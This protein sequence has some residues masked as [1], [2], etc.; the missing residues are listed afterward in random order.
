MRSTI[1]SVYGISSGFGI[2][3]GQSIAGYMGENNWRISFLVVALPAIMLAILV[4]T[5]TE[6]IQRGRMEPELQRA[7]VHS[8][9]FAYKKKSGYDSIKRM[10]KTKTNLLL[11][12]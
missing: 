2:V 9:D 4:Y 5:S 3:A 6:E 8:P 12:S 11:Y 7:F 10:L 1:A